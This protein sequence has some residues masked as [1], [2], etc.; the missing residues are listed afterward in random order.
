MARGGH[1]P[2]SIAS[3]AHMR[4]QDNTLKGP[5]SFRAKEQVICMCEGAHGGIP[6]SPHA[7]FLPPGVMWQRLPSQAAAVPGSNTSGSTPT[8]CTRPARTLLGR[9]VVRRA[10][11]WRYAW[12][13]CMAWQL[14]DGRRGPY[15]G[16]CHSSQLPGPWVQ[17]FRGLRR[18]AASRPPASG[19][20]NRYRFTRQR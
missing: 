7:P 15:I 6:Q 5:W 18:G 11:A 17:G 20:L 9:R 19:E 3:D 13:G 12:L 2:S 16:L 10:P 4:A 8:P 14:G 1:Q